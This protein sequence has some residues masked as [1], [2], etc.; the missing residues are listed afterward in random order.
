MDVQIEG[1]GVEELSWGKNEVK[2]NEGLRHGI[3]RPPTYNKIV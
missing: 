2:Y 3:G 1:L